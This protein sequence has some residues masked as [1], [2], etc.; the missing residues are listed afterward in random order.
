MKKIFAV[1]VLFCALILVVSC[2]SDSTHDNDAIT[3]FGQLGCRCYPNKTCDEGFICDTDNNVCIEDTENQT[4]DSDNGD[5]TQDGA[6]TTPDEGDSQPEGAD[7]TPDEGDS[8][9]DD[10]DTTPDEGDSQTDEGDSQSDD[11]ADTAHEPTEAEKCGSAGGTWN[12]TEETCTRTVSCIDNQ[13]NTEWNGASSYT[14]TYANGMWSAEIPAEYDTEE[15][16]CHYKCVKN[17]TRIDSECLMECSP[18]TTFPCY[19]S[20][21]RLSWSKKSADEMKWIDT[22]ES[23]N[24]IFPAQAY[25]EDLN[26]SN[27][28]GFT[29]W[30]LPEIS[31]LRTL[32][33]NCPATQMPPV[34]GVDSCAV[35]SD[36]GNVCLT[37]SC[38]TR[39]CY[40]SSYDGSGLYSKLGD[41]D[42]SLWSSS[43]QS[44]SVAWRLVFSFGMVGYCDMDAAGGQVRCVR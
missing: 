2:G 37:Y 25:C 35:R 31:E 11:D 10:A 38:Q 19:D 7:T 1:F 28:G 42:I 14:Q 32:I 41:G 30:R 20:E 3:N 9:P 43:L 15:G 12:E 8:Q 26:A 39:N 4:N 24:K 16:V 17:S 21:S 13:E 44:D 40:C 33:K 34:E 36:E 6:D 29:D 18:K 23:G 5:T 27:Y 22:D